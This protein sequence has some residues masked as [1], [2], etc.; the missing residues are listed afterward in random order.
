MKNLKIKPFSSIETKHR[1]RTKCWKLSSALHNFRG[2]PLKSSSPLNND[3]FSKQSSPF[4]EKKT[5]FRRAFVH[6]FLFSGSHVPGK[7]LQII[8]VS[9]VAGQ[10]KKVMRELTFNGTQGTRRTIFRSC[11]HV[12]WKSSFFSQ[13]S[14]GFGRKETEI[15]KGL[16]HWIFHVMIGWQAISSFELLAN[17]GHPF[18]KLQPQKGK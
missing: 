3:D 12:L 8:S 4:W 11:N 6:F 16:Q 7:N 9:L 13:Q 5:S 17:V 18:Q 14:V 15:N 1:S 2:K 10:T